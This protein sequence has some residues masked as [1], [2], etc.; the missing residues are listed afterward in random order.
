MKKSKLFENLSGIPVH[1]IL[2]TSNVYVDDKSIISTKLS[3]EQKLKM[4]QFVN[5][6]RS[7]SGIP[8]NNNMIYEDKECNYLNELS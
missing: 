3:L 1:Q 2:L 7:N 8:Y 6:N 5:K 4:H